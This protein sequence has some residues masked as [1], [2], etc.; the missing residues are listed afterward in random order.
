MKRITSFLAG[1]IVG[2]AGLYG[3][4]TYHFVRA[5]DGVHLVPKV[6]SGL[7]DTYVDI[8]KFNTAS[9][10]EHKSLAVAL[11]N[12]DKQ[13]LLKDPAIV[14]LRQAAQNTLEAL[15]LK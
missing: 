13:D 14:D 11:V 8:R 2:A 15:G 5:E 4:M 3:A 10:Y 6:T 12:A 9:W 1:V 7:S